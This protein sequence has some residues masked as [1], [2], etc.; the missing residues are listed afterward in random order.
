MWGC[1]LARQKGPNGGARMH[2][3]RT[4]ML[5]SLLESLPEALKA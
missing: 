5:L 1:I 4:T 3:M 2:G